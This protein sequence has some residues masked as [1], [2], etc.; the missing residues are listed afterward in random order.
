MPLSRSSESKS[1]DAKRRRSRKSPSPLRSYTGEV[2]RPVLAAGPFAE[3]KMYD[4]AADQDRREDDLDITQVGREAKMPW[5]IDGRRWHTVD[6]VARN[7][8]PCRWDGRVLG[9]VVDRVMRR[10]DLFSEA[11]WGN[12]TI[13]EIRAARKSHGWFFHA[14]TGEEWLLKLKFRTAKNTFQR[15]ELLRRLD[16]K[17]LNDMPD[18]PLYGTEPRLRCKNLRGPWQEVELRVH[19]YPEIDRP[20]FWE[21]VDRAVAGFGKFTQRARSKPEDLMPWK[22]LGR[23][24]HFLRRGFLKG[25]PPRWDPELLEEV[26]RL[27]EQTAP[28][29]QFGWGNKVWVPVHVAG[30]KR[31]WAGVVTKKPDAVHLA[32][33]GPKNR[34]PLGRLTDLGHEPELNAD[35]PDHDQIQLKFRSPDD[36]ARGDLPGFLKEHLAAVNNKE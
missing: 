19:A 28:G 13:V 30:H 2:L 6:R 10:A 20:E 26:C 17:P 3:R 34:F 31:P 4:F 33:F 36:L 29:C 16:L 27:L 23:K 11:D 9:E 12:R 14:I 32:L 1:A 25:G 22:A 35:Q 15:E 21:F 5:Q 8:K 7:G 24:W 18:L